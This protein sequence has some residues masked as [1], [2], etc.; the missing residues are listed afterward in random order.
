MNAIES[1]HFAQ[2]DRFNEYSVRFADEGHQ[3]ITNWKEF[4]ARWGA[5]TLGL[6]Y[7]GVLVGTGVLDGGAGRVKRDVKTHAMELRPAFR[8]KGHGIWLYLAIIE[9]ARMIGADRIYS[10]WYLNKFSRRMW[11]E[12]LSKIFKV[13]NRNERNESHCNVCH[14]NKRYFI[15]LGE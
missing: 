13:H 7:N 2:V 3:P 1:E 11:R 8:R 14:H 6:Y 9:Q 15:N 5:A 12:K 10:S 4:K